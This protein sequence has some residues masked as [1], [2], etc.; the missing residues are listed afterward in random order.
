MMASVPVLA[1]TVVY[2]SGATGPCG[3]ALIDVKRG[4]ANESACDHDRTGPTVQDRRRDAIDLTTA[5]VF[6]HA[7]EGKSWKCKYSVDGENITVVVNGT[8]SIACL[9]GMRPERLASVL[10]R[11]ILV[12]AAFRS[13]LT[14]D[15]L[16]RRGD[17][18]QRSTSS[19]L[20]LA[21]ST[22]RLSPRI[23]P[24]ERPH[25]RPTPASPRC[26]SGRLRPSDGRPNLGKNSQS[27]RIRRRGSELP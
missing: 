4:G 3:I 12:A 15:R 6:D 9:D 18:L 17:P 14:R 27:V 21:K 25:A 26:P 20:A 5:I 11:E 19:R 7:F 8:K 23:S 1:A 13:W 24:G 2:A 10:A 16:A 22:E